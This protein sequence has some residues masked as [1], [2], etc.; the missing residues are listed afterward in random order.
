MYLL[1]KYEK[2]ICLE[3]ACNYINSNYN[4]RWK[5]RNILKDSKNNIIIVD[6]LNIFLL[7]IEDLIIIKNGNNL[8]IGKKDS[9]QDIKK[10]K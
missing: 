4:G 9:A 1:D 6:D 10:I 7:G 2:E 8:L 3:R 5:W